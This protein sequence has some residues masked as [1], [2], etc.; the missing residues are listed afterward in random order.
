MVRSQHEDILRWTPAT[1]GQCTSKAIYS[2]L[3]GLNQ[4]PL[5]SQGSRSI[6]QDANSILQK[7]WKAKTIPP[8][9]KT[10]TWRLI[11]RALATAERAGRYSSYID[12]HCS[13]C[14]AIE[15]DVHLF[16]TCDLPK[17]VW[18][19]SGTPCLPYMITPDE[20]GVQQTLPAFLTPAPTEST[21][22]TT[23]FLLWYIWK[24]RNDQRFQRKTWT[25]FQVHKVA[26]AHQQTHL[27]ACLEHRQSTTS[28]DP[29]HPNSP[30]DNPANRYLVQ[31]P[32]SLSGFRC[33]TDASTLPDTP[34]NTNRS[35]GLGIFIVNTEMQPLSACFSKLLCRTLPLLLWL[36]LQ[37]LLWPLPCATEWNF[38][39]YISSQITNYW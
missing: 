12:Q 39:M 8:F 33:Y 11:R 35:A 6:T 34:H 20:D 10:F 14:G 2:H 30:Q 16:F 32:S 29:H 24:A 18:A 13:S 4:H 36:N 25:S 19:T 31:L 17:Q 38:I 27:S 28:R 9:L 21:L 5:P 7:V 15:N 23:L 37:L 1:N 26:A 3:S 22:C